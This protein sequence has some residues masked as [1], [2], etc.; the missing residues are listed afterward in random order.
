MLIMAT[1]V[2]V[3]GCGGCGTN[4]VLNYVTVPYTEEIPIYPKTKKYIFDTSDSNVKYAD[5]VPVFIVPGE[6]GA[7]KQRA[8]AFEMIKPHI[9]PFLNQHK[10]SEFNIFVFSASGGSGSVIGPMLM[11]EVLRRGLPAVA[12]V[13]GS[14]ASKDEATNTFNTLTTLQT[15]AAKNTGGRP[16]GIIYMEDVPTF[17]EGLPDYCLSRV[18]VDKAVQEAVRAMAIIIAGTHKELDHADVCNLFDYSRTSS[19]KK[20]KPQLFEILPFKEDT[21]SA[22]MWGERRL[23][24]FRSN[25]LGIASVLNSEENELPDLGQLYGAV[26]YYD[27]E[28]LSR[29]EREIKL[30]NLHVASSLARIPDIFARAAN[31]RD[32]YIKIEHELA[33]R[34]IVGTSDDSDDTGMVL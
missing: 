34:E 26:G 3:Y 21:G 13:T 22:P 33:N 23:E 24:D 28:K 32:L 1:T 10:P 25:L 8:S 27:S 7:G 4:Q 5:G 12:I 2:S 19:G 15:M 31:E 6:K 29:A 16:M 11:A 14:T 18:S 30:P 9:V 17:R 20:I